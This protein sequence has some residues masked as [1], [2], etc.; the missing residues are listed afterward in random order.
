[1]S[2]PPRLTRRALG[3]FGLGLGLAAQLPGWARAAATPAAAPAATT[4]SHGVS[5]FGDLK[6]P[7]DFSHFDYAVPDAPVG[8]TFSQGGGDT[9]FDSLNQFV[10]KGDPAVLLGLL[11]DTLMTGADDEPD[12]MYG[13]L[14]STIELPADRAWAAFN[15]RP[16]AR[17][18]DGSP[19]TADD[20]AWTFDTLMTQGHPSYRLNYAS[21]AACVAEGPGRVRY[22]FKPG[23]PKRDL[24]MAVAGLP[25]LSRA[26]YA[27]RDFTQS[28][29]E[30][31][32]GSGPYLVEKAEPG[33]VIVYRRRADYWGWSLPVNRG[34]FHFERIRYEYFRDRS[35][36]FEGFKSGAYS[37]H[38]EFSSKTWA[39]G[40]EFPA[41][42]RGDVVRDTLP[43]NRTAGTQG[44]WFNLRRP[45]FADPRVR[46]AIGLAFDFE[47]SNKT[48]FYGLYQR[49]DSFF[50]GGPMQ[51]AGEPTPG[52]LALLEP[53]RAQLPPAVFGPAVVPPVTDGSGR[54]RS[55]LAEAGR[56][57]DAA[58]WP[59]VN[60][61]R[62]RNGEVLSI[63]FLDAT[64]AF[65]RITVPF[66][67][68]LERLG[69]Q[70]ANR[71]ID[72][73]Q[74]S[75]RMKTFDFDMT[76]DRKAMSLTPGVELRNYFHS[77]SANSSGSENTA[78]ISDPAVDALIEAIERAPDR[79][80]LTDAVK[81]LDRVLRAMHIWVPQW[82]KGSHTIA[83]WDIYG[84][85]PEKPKYALGVLDLW[86][87][88]PAKHARLQAQVGG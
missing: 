25:V 59:V 3:R 10:L 33:R 14:A 71:T 87:V 38:E 49:T 52:E 83:Y 26:W 77:G 76:T 86:W 67:K 81:A 82:S 34:R 24:P 69:I 68:N 70:A 11:F 54:N 42:T 7:A 60:G 62:T 36:A 28:S 48:L 55:Q 17:F 22:D 20:I 23:A 9:T 12:A 78:G 72:P 51:A 31:P 74:Y 21:V 13:L 32:L 56:L 46:Q 73:T 2:I 58:G 4:A 47:W 85:P 84:R 80:A 6:Y 79:A 41:V 63:E 66:T 61:K 65:E 40:Y 39:T 45:K 64:E 53:L 57:L 15:L 5:A 50:E 37:F 35:V 27:N 29:L 44:Y 88:D 18:S 43:D 1:M 16:E 75:E 19:V 30:A 8:G